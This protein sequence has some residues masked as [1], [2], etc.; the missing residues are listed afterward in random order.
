MENPERSQILHVSAKQ[1]PTIHLAQN[2][3]PTW[4]KIKSPA[5]TNP[6]NIFPFPNCWKREW[7]T[8]LTAWL[9]LVALH[10]PSFMLRLYIYIYPHL[11]LSLFLQQTKTQTPVT[12][13]LLLTLFTPS[14]NKHKH[15]LLLSFLVYFI[16]I[17]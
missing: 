1:K 3:I 17:N 8:T 5:D 10:V 15:H 14:F 16:D 4:L 7:G 6:T 13:L 9:V 12:Y 11:S 2:K